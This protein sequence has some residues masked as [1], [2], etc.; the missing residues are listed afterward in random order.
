MSS[1][2]TK[3][4]VNIAASSSAGA[5]GKLCHDATD[6]ASDSIVQAETT[7]VSGG[8]FPPYQLNEAARASRNADRVPKVP[9]A[10]EPDAVLNKKRD[11]RRVPVTRSRG[12]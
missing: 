9:I 11:P 12:K 3:P 4:D 8:Q 2:A 5:D 7:T 10:A 1:K 6:L